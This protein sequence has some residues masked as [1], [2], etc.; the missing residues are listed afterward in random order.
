MQL[1]TPQTGPDGKLVRK[2]L[3]AQDVYYPGEAETEEYY[4]SIL[5]DR[6]QAEI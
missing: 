1:V 5:L 3:V 2:V 6:K 4:M